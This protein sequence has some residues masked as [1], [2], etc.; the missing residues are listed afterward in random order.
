MKFAI[1]LLAASL[2]GYSSTP[3]ADSLYF[4]GLA[5]RARVLDPQAISEI[6]ALSET[7]LPGEQLEE[8]AELAAGY[9][10]P[11]PVL[12]LQA[13]SPMTSCFGVSF[14]GSKFVDDS[15]G[16]ESELA[17]RQSALQTVTDPALVVTKNR[18]LAELHGS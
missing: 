10:I 11:R 7:T 3:V 1:L 12:F 17:A 9:V 5:E 15:S 16:R 6:L 8:L 13:Q 14:L 18:C 4:P 2:I